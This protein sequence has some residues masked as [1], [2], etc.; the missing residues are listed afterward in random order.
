MKNKEILNV[1]KITKRNI[2]SIFLNFF[3]AFYQKSLTPSSIQSPINH[4]LQGT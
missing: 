1:M 4:A 3:A 2:S